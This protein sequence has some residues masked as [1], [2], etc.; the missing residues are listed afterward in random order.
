[1]KRYLILLTLLGGFGCGGAVADSNHPDNRDPYCIPPAAEKYL[2]DGA[3]SY[4]QNKDGTQWQLR[5][6]GEAWRVT[7]VQ[8]TAHSVESITCDVAPNGYVIYDGHQP[9]E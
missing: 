1:M 5:A 3:L 4:T 7:V 6:S 2:Q 8:G 9:T